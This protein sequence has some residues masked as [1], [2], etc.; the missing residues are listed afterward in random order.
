MLDQEP[1]PSDH[2]SDSPETSKTKP[3][4][5]TCV[6]IRIHDMKDFKKKFKASD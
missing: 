2:C 5:H 6:G 4:G 1:R 3:T